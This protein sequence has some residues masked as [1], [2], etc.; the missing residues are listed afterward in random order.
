M[1][2]TY[3]EPESGENGRWAMTNRPLLPIISSSERV[4]LAALT[5]CGGGRWGSARFLKGS[6]RLG[7]GVLGALL[8]QEGL[9]EAESVSLAKLE[10]GSGVGVV[11]GGVQVGLGFAPICRGLGRGLKSLLRRD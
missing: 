8:L 3:P 10:D 5:V 2:S 11:S 6:W 9:G 7:R 4:S 1:R